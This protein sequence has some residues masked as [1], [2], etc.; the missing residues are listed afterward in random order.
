MS[1]IS[2]RGRWTAKLAVAVFAGAGLL[3]VA[4]DAHAGPDFMGCSLTQWPNDILNCLNGKW[5]EATNNFQRQIDDAKKQ[6]DEARRSVDD[7][8]KYAVDN[9]RKQLENAGELVKSNTEKALLQAS[10]QVGADQ[11]VACLARANPSA[12]VSQM[13]A[14]FASDPA[15]FLQ[16]TYDEAAALVGPFKLVA[17]KNGAIRLPTAGEIFDQS[18]GRLEGIGA[19]SASVGCVVEYLRPMKDAMKRGFTGSAPRFTAAMSG[20]WSA[21]G[22]SVLASSVAKLMTQMLNKTALGADGVLIL[23]GALT[24]H[25]LGPARI[26]SNADLVHALAAAMPAGG[27]PLAEAAARAKDAL[28]KTFEID[29]DFYVDLF[30]TWLKVTGHKVIRSD[31]PMVYGVP[32]GGWIADRL[33]D[34][35]DWVPGAVNSAIATTCGGV[36]EVGGAVC[37]WAMQLPLRELWIQ[38]ARPGI[39]EV[40]LSTI[41]AA[42]DSGTE[43]IKDKLRGQL[44]QGADALRQAA[45]PFAGALESMQKQL[46]EAF[47]DDVVKATRVALDNYNDSVVDLIDAATTGR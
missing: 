20:A 6:A 40:A 26:Q 21:S 15:A 36:P 30:G 1:G 16:S 28:G 44:R 37:A 8:V 12:E 38:V 4:R 7:K 17:P 11:L 25:M 32:G 5:S 18:W 24:E 10:R 45:G 23:K 27:A 42:Y 33:L 47:V 19:R 9:L 35:L 2:N 43:L 29:G 31:S 22:D 41:E 13:A 34:Q 3:A 14:R 39:K 46:V